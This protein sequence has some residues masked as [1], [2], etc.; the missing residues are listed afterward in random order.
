MALN[1]VDA[2]WKWQIT[3]AGLP[4]KGCD[5]RDCSLFRASMEWLASD[6]SAWFRDLRLSGTCNRP[7]T[8]SRDSS[9][10]ASSF[11][12]ERELGY[13]RLQDLSVDTPLR[14]L[15]SEGAF[16]LASTSDPPCSEIRLKGTFDE[17]QNSRPGKI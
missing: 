3:R 7:A 13:L 8:L 10:L 17:F 11:R 6:D 1:L 14:G 9:P 16:E 15:E 2:F 12:S 5:G 4:G